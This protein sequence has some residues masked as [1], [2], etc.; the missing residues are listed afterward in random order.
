MKYAILAT[1]PSMSQELADSLKGQHVIVVNDAYKLAPWAEALAAQDAAWWA[2]H[3]EAKNFSGRKFSTNSIAGVERITNAIVQTS[4]S[5]G[6]L[7]LVVAAQ[8]GATEIDLHGFDMHGDHYFGKHPNGLNTTTTAR[9]EIFQQ[10]F[11]MW[12]KQNDAI[13]VINRT[14]G[15]QLRTFPHG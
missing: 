2:M 13:K 9:Y 11:A 12:A 10:Q 4:S 5:S 14:P 6:V 8:L 15:S 3:P 7:A 1:G